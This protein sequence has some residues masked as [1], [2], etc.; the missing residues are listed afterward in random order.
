M[1]RT[2]SLK[3]QSNQP[4]DVLKHV[5]YCLGKDTISFQDLVFYMAFDLKLF[6][7]SGC[8]KLLKAA[9]DEGLIDIAADK[10]VTI[11][12]RLLVGAGK[13]ASVQDVVNALALDEAEITKAVKIKP[14]SMTSCKVDGKTG[15]LAITFEG[16]T[17]GK[18]F[19]FSVSVDPAKK[20]LHQECDGDVAALKNKRVLLRHALRAV[21]LRKDDKQVLDVFRDVLARVKDW[22]FT[23]GR[24]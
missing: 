8:E 17:P 2:I 7:P 23:Y 15:V 3:P 18:P 12:S 1:R 14:D 19:S 13:E 24:V 22:E 6:P 9:R 4:K 10:V 21:M 5:H 16:D 11:N 20:T